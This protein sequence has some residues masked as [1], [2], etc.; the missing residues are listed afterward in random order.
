M[1][2]LLT[3]LLVVSLSMEVGGDIHSLL[4]D[5]DEAEH[6]QR[7]NRDTLVIDEYRKTLIKEEIL[8]RLGLSNPPNISS[9][10]VLP[11]QILQNVLLQKSSESEEI[12]KDT[13]AYYGVTR[14]V[15]VMAEP[16]EV[17]QISNNICIVVKISKAFFR[18]QC[19]ATVFHSL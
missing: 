12:T 5:L 14:Q 19:L 18:A 7:G 11:T 17:S 2:K 4:R 9:N 8:N 1:R 16:G 3:F 13:N 15:V 6:E 10:S